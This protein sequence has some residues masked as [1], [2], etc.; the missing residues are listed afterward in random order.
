MKNLT[1]VLVFSTTLMLVLG[2]HKNTGEN[3]GPTDSGQTPA[4]A[5]PSSTTKTG[6]DSGTTGSDASTLKDA[7][8]EPARDQAALEACVDNWLK[9][10]KL[11]A[12]GNT[13]GTMYAGGTPLFDERTGESKDRMEFVFRGHPEARKVCMQ[14]SKTP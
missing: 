14:P 2:C 5:A 9:K 7:A 13:E 3:P 8:G 11:D 6:A 10:H 1:G 12:Y 4:S